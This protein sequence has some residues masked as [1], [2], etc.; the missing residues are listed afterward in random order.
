MGHRFVFIKR[1]TFYG[2]E[3]SGWKTKCI[4]TEMTQISSVTECFLLFLTLSTIAQ[5]AKMKTFV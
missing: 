4:A 5:M 2:V 3:L 1:R